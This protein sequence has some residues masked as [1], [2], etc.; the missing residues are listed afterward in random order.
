MSCEQTGWWL[1]MLR[2]TDGS[3]Y[4]GIARDVA[5]RVQVHNSGKGAKYTRGRTPVVPVY[6]EPCESH[7]AAL[8]REREVKKLTRLQ[9]LALVAAFNQGAH[10]GF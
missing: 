10:N 3:L 5:H 2:C 1:Y 4:T 9:K 7:T 6:I 8:Q